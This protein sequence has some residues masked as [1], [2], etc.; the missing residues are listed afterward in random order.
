M[1]AE[2]RSGWVAAKSVH[3]DPPSEAPRRAARSDPTLSMTEVRSSICCSMM[4][5]S[6]DRSE[7][8]V[9]RLSKR[10]RR[11]NE[12][13]RLRKRAQEGSSQKSSMLPIHAGA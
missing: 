6:T 3:S 9:P 7:L 8:P 5:I 11:E 4:G 13:R 1:S 2:V 10:I 12:A